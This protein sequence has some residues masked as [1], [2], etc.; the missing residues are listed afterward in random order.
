MPELKTVSSPVAVE[1]RATPSR[2]LFG[3]H[4]PDRRTDVG[5]RGK[6][7]RPVEVQC[8]EPVCVLEGQ[9]GFGGEIVEL[10]IDPIGI[11]GSQPQVLIAKT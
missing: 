5:A 4:I 9:L 6:L 11:A 7:P 2:R 10:R 3:K 1:D 8:P